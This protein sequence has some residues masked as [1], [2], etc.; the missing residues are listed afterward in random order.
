MPYPLYLFTINLTPCTIY[1]CPFPVRPSLHHPASKPLR[2]GIN[3]AATLEAVLSFLFPSAVNRESNACSQSSH[4]HL[5]RTFSPSFFCSPSHLPIFSPS[6]FPF[7]REPCALRR[8][9]IL[10][11]FG[12]QQFPTPACLPRHSPALQGRRRVRLPTSRLTF[13]FFP[14]RR[15]P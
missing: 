6:F 14:L 4:L 3:P 7:R 8:F 5:L 1:C 12:D 10:S 2:A 11:T 9:L 13:L 15:E